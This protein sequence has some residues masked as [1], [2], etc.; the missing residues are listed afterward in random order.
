MFPLLMVFLIFLQ[1]LNMLMA[2]FLRV[3]L[4]THKIF[5]FFFLGKYN[6]ILEIAKVFGTFRNEF[7]T[8]L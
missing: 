1:N 4:Y 7:E 5:K 6:E 8:F 2:R 3:I